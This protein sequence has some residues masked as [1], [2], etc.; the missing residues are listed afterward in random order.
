MSI[1]RA[2]TLLNGKS[3]PTVGFGTYMI[4]SNKPS[5]EAAYL[6]CQ[7]GYRHFDTATMYGNERDVA[8]GIQRFLDE[9]PGVERKDI[10]YTTK[11]MHTRSYELLAREIQQCLAQI[12]DTL[13]YIDLL[14][15]HLPLAGPT[16]RLETW[17]AMQEAADRG[18]AVSLGVLNYGVQHLE[19]LL[20]WDGLRIPPVA[21]EIE[22]LPWCMRQ[23]LCA[24]CLEHRIA[25]LAY[26]PLT[27][28]QRI[29]DPAVQTVAARH[30]V[31]TAQVLVRWSLQKGYIP[32]PK[33]ATPHRMATNLDVY[34]FAL[35]A[36]ELSLLDHPEAYEPSDWECTT[37]A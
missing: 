26:A 17:R 7:A 28:D 4:S 22:V 1:L 11:L 16:A 19:Q 20:A 31:S 25:V 3:I 6:A 18:E 21:N 14:L 8:Q 15:I 34:L 30:G 23:E 9:T 36:E 5:S 27:H 33:T 13:G 37:C 29:N 12:K 32:L 24:W 2:T 35:S 10:F